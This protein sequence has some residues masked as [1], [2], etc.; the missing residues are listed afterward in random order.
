MFGEYMAADKCYSV[1]MGALSFKSI[2]TEQADLWEKSLRSQL[3]IVKSGLRWLMHRMLS[4]ENTEG[5]FG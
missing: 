5:L 3:D 1:L 2:I 4:L